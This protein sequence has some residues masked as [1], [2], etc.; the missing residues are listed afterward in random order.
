M[1]F[2]ADKVISMGVAVSA[3]VSPSDN[4]TSIH[5]ADDGGSSGSVPHNPLSL[6]GQQDGTSRSSDDGGNTTILDR[7]AHNPSQEHFQLF[8]RDIQAQG[9]Q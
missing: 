1:E 4:S 2:Q 8:I 3:A 7:Q 9:E 6:A 5:S